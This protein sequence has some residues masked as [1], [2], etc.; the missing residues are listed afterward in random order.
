MSTDAIDALIKRL[1]DMS[2]E[3][4][5]NQYADPDEAADAIDTW[6]ELY[7]EESA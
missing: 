2:A 6:I 7:E 5:A 3:L 4:R 1:R